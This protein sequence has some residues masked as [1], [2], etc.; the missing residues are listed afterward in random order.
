M[1]ILLIRRDDILRICPDDVKKRFS[2]EELMHIARELGAFW[3]YDYVAAEKG[4]VGQHALLKSGRHSDGFFASKILLEH[5]NILEIMARQ[6]ARTSSCLGL[7][8]IA[9]VPNG[10]TELAQKTAGF[11][12]GVEVVKLE[13][14]DGFIRLLS[15]IPPG[16]AVLFV[17]D[18]CTRGTGFMEAV[19]EVILRCK[20]AV[21][22]PW[23]LCIINRGGLSVIEMENLGKFLIFPIA[24]VRIT[25]WEK[26]ECPLC[27]MGS[28]P[29][30]PKESQ[31]NWKGLLS[32]QA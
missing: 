2:E 27:K 29:V 18:F 11:L 31:E 1:N 16:S 3:Q 24:E 6:I 20:D 12:P 15:D 5:E 8:H 32:P 21:V 10:A 26:E 23:L 9:G 25:D 28:I 19:H 14:I 30:K 17:E 4:R 22:L 13:K 7:S